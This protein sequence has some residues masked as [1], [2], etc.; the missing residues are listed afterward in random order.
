MLFC[1]PCKFLLLPCPVLKTKWLPCPSVDLCRKALYYNVKMNA[2]FVLLLFFTNCLQNPA[3]RNSSLFMV[4]GNLKQSSEESQDSCDNCQR[5]PRSSR[6]GCWSRIW[7]WIHLTVCCSCRGVTWVSEFRS[8]E[9]S[10][11]GD[12]WPWIWTVVV[13]DVWVLPG[14]QIWWEKC[15]WNISLKSTWAILS[16]HCAPIFIYVP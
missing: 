12:C 10:G 14:F 3:S 16:F 15:R 5:K 8:G 13:V 7:I 1:P 6:G 4:V 9:S 11:V 2:F